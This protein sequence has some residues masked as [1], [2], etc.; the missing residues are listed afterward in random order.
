MAFERVLLMAPHGRRLI[1]G[2]AAGELAP[3]IRP[4]ALA[5]LGALLLVAAPAADAQSMTQG[6]RLSL[7]IACKVGETCALQNHVD[8]D[9]GPGAKD[10]RCGRETYQAHGGVDIRLLD[11]AAQKRGVDV[12]AAAP[13]RVSRLRDG[14]PDISIKSPDA[15]PLAGQDCGNGVVIDH[16][17]GWETQYCHLARGSVRVKQG[18]QVATGQPIA[19]VGLSGNTEY[20]HVHLTVRRGTTTIDPFAP[21]LAPGA[22]DPNATAANGMWD[23]A[24]AKSL[25]YVS[26]AVLN[27]GFAARQLSMDDIEAGGVAAPTPKSPLLIAYVRAI[28]LQAGD[29][30]AIAITP[31]RWIDP[32]AKRPSPAGRPEGAISDVCGQADTSSRVAARRLHGRICCEARRRLGDQPDLRD[33]ALIDAE[34]FTSQMGDSRSSR[35]ERL[36]RQGLLR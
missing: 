16:G 4:A 36:L 25:A 20:P 19:Q 10:Y 17:D 11:M 34:S 28:N 5:T 12:L 8:R 3:M 1:S 9:P 29:V 26:G 30:Q 23:A 27:T 32:G 22:C 2:E 7:P 6:P 13:G 21:G 24:A 35:L 15:P 14:V 33:S 18:D 31:P